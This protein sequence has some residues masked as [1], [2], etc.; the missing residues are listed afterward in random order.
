MKTKANHH[1]LR[2]LLT[3]LGLSLLPTY[4]HAERA[5]GPR[6]G[7]LLAVEPHAVE[8]FV[9]ADGHAELTFPAADGVETGAGTAEITLI[10]EPG[11]GRTTVALEPIP[12]GF[13]STAP[14][15]G[16]TP[17][18]VV[19]QV[20]SAP[21]SAPRNSRLDLNL[22]TCGGCQRA[23]YACTCEGH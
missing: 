20:R 13:R 12:H 23:E 18:R 6:G 3:T 21:G 17:Y 1:L 14:L 5:V 8:F 16:P 9:T 4:A 7:L 10:A 2:I 11:T 22:A 19:V 15:P